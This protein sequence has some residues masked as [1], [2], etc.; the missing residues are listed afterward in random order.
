[1]KTVTLC[2]IVIF[3]VKLVQICGF[4]PTVA[5]YLKS[6]HDKG[7]RRTLDA[8]DK[9]CRPKSSAMRCTAVLNSCGPVDRYDM[10]LHVNKNFA[11]C[12]AAVIDPRREI[13]CNTEMNGAAIEAVGFDM[14]Y[15]LAQ[16]HN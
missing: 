7:F 13:F 1:M 15:T 8:A 2:F 16:V 12:D 10:K 4:A 3:S 5:N 14:D 11:S 9:F 6:S